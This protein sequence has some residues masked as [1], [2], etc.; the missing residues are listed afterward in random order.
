M[1]A[2][3]AANLR[4][5]CRQSVVP[6]GGKNRA[7]GADS[8]P[9]RRDLFYFAQRQRREMQPWA[10]VATLSC[11]RI[12]FHRYRIMYALEA[13]SRPPVLGS[14]AAVLGMRSQLTMLQGDASL[15]ENTQRGMETRGEK[16]VY[17][18]GR[19]VI[20]T[21]LGEPMRPAI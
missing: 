13:R 21:V 4:A 10:G 11:T 18:N 20:L 14:A 6:P 12:Q 15:R 17:F 3:S 19:D 1:C 9:T 2:A 8:E 5:V 7:I 16:P